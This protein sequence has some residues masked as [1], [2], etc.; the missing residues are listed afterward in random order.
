MLQHS[1]S[2]TV[3]DKTTQEQMEIQS[4]LEMELNLKSE[5]SCGTDNSRK[6]KNEL[7]TFKK[8]LSCFEC[9][10]AFTSTSKLKIHE[11]IH[12]GE[13]P[14]YCSQCDYKCKTSGDLKTHERTHTG[15]KPF[16]C[17]KCNKAFRESGNLKIHER[18]HT[19][20]RQFKKVVQLRTVFNRF[21]SKGN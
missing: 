17:S 18:I 8:P 7:T 10:K 6:V 13:K 12:N 15:E 9:G 19:R 1:Y 3:G 4:A 16:T 5:F 20:G 14:L 21:W 2:F 11:R